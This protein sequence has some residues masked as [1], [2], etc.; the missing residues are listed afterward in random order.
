MCTA[1]FVVFGVIVLCSMCHSVVVLVCL[2]V[3]MFVVFRVQK[4][5][6]YFFYFYF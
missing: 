1:V 6:V 2:F 4:N 5:A 3:F